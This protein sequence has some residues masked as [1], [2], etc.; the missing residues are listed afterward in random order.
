MFKKKD[1]SLEIEMDDDLRQS[2][3]GGAGEPA[4]SWAT[5]PSG[6]A[7]PPPRG[8]V[9]APRWTRIVHFSVHAFCSLLIAILVLVLVLH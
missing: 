1:A 7:K 3:K 9:P 6:R 5:A 2:K 8:M 4:P